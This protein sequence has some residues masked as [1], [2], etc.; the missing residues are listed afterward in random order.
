MLRA[1]FFDEIKSIYSNLPPSA[2]DQLKAG[3]LN[4]HLKLSEYYYKYDESPFYTWAA[5]ELLTAVLNHLLT[6]HIFLAVLD[7]RISYEGVRDDYA[8]D[9]DLAAY[10]EVAKCQLHD[11]YD[12]HYAGRH[13][14]ANPGTSST[15]A[16]PLPHQHLPCP[17]L[18][19]LPG[20]GK[21]GPLLMSSR[22]TLN[23]LLKILTP[24]IL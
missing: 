12:S 11:H 23:C 8:S 13:S 17:R 1:E 14:A 7:P 10:L 22:S 20:T 2:P 9:P 3:L 16:Q 18:I 24:V 6:C 19:S 21:I 15:A 5:C 4:A